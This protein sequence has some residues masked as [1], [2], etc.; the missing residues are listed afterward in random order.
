MDKRLDIEIREAYTETEFVHPELDYWRLLLQNISH[1]DEWKEGLPDGE[2][3]IY[4]G[5]TPNGFSW[6]LDQPRA[7]WFANRFKA[8]G[9]VDDVYTMLVTKEDVLWYTDERNEQ[10]VVLFPNQ[11][12]VEKLMETLE[13]EKSTG[14]VVV[15]PTTPPET[16][17]MGLLG[18]LHATCGECGE[19]VLDEEG[20]VD[21]RVQAS[22]KCGHCAYG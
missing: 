8:I 15:R 12:K 22:M 7:T 6:T 11:K 19:V 14:E 5:G 9:I 1:R 21:E 20:G 3:R 18:A 4:R 2:F 16:A 10:E 13:C 17:A